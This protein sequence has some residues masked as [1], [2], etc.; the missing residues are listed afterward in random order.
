MVP[1]K[2]AVSTCYRY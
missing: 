1:V 2:S